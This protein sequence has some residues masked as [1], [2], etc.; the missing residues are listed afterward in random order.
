MNDRLVSNRQKHHGMSWSKKGSAA[1]AALAALKRN[2]EYQ[3]WFEYQEIA[4]KQA[5]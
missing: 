2:K 5:S 3:Y 1:L 4:L